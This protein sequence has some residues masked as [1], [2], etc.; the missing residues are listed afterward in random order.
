[1]SLDPEQRWLSR[2]DCPESEGVKE[3]GSAKEPHFGGGAPCGLWMGPQSSDAGISSDT[4]PWTSAPKGKQGFWAESSL[5][6]SP[7][8][9]TL[10]P[11]G[12][13]CS[14]CLPRLRAHSKITL[15]ITVWVGLGNLL[16]GGVCRGGEKNVKRHEPWHRL[17]TQT[18]ERSSL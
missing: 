7:A 15:S 9:E 12:P 14:P 8:P 13:C 3:H 6:S 18:L 4:S 10:S 17:P 5:K 11:W 1:M 16:G 2:L